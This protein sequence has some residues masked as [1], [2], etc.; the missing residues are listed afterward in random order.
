MNDQT[1]GF[2]VTFEEKEE[3]RSHAKAA[4]LKLSDYL[5]IA[6]LRSPKIMKVN[7]ALALL[8]LYDG[9]EFRQEVVKEVNFIINTFETAKPLLN[10]EQFSLVNELI[11]ALSIALKEVERKGEYIFRLREGLAHEFWLYFLCPDLT[12]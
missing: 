9:G 5:R 6:L 2:K 10:R 1:I 4:N 8:L 3:L 12:D 7:Q 11:L